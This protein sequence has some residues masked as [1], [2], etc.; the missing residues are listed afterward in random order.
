MFIIDKPYIS[1]LFR[2]TVRNHDIP[3]IATP[4]A[5]DLALF[6]GT[7]LISEEAAVQTARE[8]DRLRVYTTSENAIGWLA[9]HFSA[10]DLPDK[11]D[12]FKDK[13]K[14]R[15]I[16]ADIFPGF[17]FTGVPLTELREFDISDI[18][19]PFIIKPAV[20]F[21]SMGVHK[22]TEHSEWLTVVETI[23]AEID[24]TNELYPLEVL[25]T[26]TFI[27]EQCIE[28][29]EYAVDAYYDDAG[30]AVILS[31]FHHSFSSDSDVSDRVYT[32]SKEIVESNLE[33]FTIFVAGIGQATAVKNFP[34]HIELRRD[35][36]GRI[37]PIEVNPMRF[38]GWC[39]TADMTTLAFGVNPYLCYYRQEKPDW[40]QALSGKENI[41][42][43][44]IVLDNSTGT[45]GAD[46]EHFHYEKLM[47]GFEKPLELRKVDFRKYP[48]FG[49]LFTET[50]PHNFAELKAILD[51]DLREFITLA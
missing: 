3:V 12:L 9:A 41:L 51:S 33:E 17:S 47:A 35:L 40:Q 50:R 13:L 11:I 22:V 8:N 4:A 46:I 21:F 10:T 23:Q 49:F 18:P 29:E 48:V 31:I 45:A 5:M 20:G 38:G 19:V 44:L 7:I 2:E 34:V 42:Y 25:N 43:S 14:F 1:D 6:D 32:T 36:D 24:Q 37:L 39:T 16:T 30:D 27:I 28:G 15:E 26:G